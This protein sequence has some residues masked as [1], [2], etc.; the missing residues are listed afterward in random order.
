MIRA[1]LFDMG[2]T[3]DGDGQHWLDRFVALYRSFG[4]TLPRERLRGA[5]DEA[6]RRANLDDTIGSANFQ[7]MIELYVTWQLDHL[8]LTSGRLKQDLVAGFSGPVRKAVASNVELLAEL[9]GRGF[10]LGVVSNGCGN[11]EQLCADFGYTPFLSVIVDSRRVGIFKPDPA[12]FA[13]AVEKVGREPGEIMMVGDSFERDVRPSK[14]IGMKTAWLEG[15]ERRDC[16]EPALVDLHLRTLAELRH[17]AI[18]SP[19]LV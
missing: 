2:G 8:G 16:P 12:I 6:E 11:V 7:Q 9:A 18:L 5:F 10:E 15:I 17:A 13:Y 14:K 4:V 3:L 1:I 19:A